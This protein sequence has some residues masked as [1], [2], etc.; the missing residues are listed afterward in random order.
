MFFLLALATF[1]APCP[2]PVRRAGLLLLRRAPRGARWS[3]FSATVLTSRRLA[4]L[5]IPPPRHR[6]SPSGS[7]SSRRP[8]Q[9]RNTS[10]RQSADRRPRQRPGLDP[11]QPAAPTVYLETSALLRVHA[12]GR[13]IYAGPDTPEIYALTGLR[14]PTRSLF[15]V[16]DPSNSARGKQLLATLEARNVTA[17]AI[18]AVPAFSN[19]LERGVEARLRS[20]YPHH[21]RLARSRF[22]GRQPRRAV[23]VSPRACMQR[24]TRSRRQGLPVCRRAERPRGTLGQ[25]P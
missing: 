5:P 25:P 8:L 19:P 15:D 21:K 3:R 10:E 16:L 11:G 18:N 23:I 1:V 12:R 14:N 6:S 22:A 2:V 20:G 9:G 13:Y 7:S 24:R 17:I 4:C